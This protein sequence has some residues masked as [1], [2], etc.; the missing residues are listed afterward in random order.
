[1]PETRLDSGSASQQNMEGEAVISGNK[2][3]TTFRLSAFEGVG[4]EWQWSA[5]TSVDGR[6]ADSCPDQGD[7]PLKPNMGKL[8]ES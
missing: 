5:T 1:M 7:D 6:D 4:P 2:I 8:P 3:I